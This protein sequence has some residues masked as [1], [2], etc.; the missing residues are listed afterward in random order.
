M[1]DTHTM[2]MVKTAL[3][4]MQR[5]PWEQGVASHAFIDADDTA[6]AIA[7][8]HEAAYRQISDGRLA[9]IGEPG[10]VTD[11]CSPGEA[12]AYAYQKTGDPFFKTAL[13]RVKTWALKN[14][15]RSEEGIVYHVIDRPV[16]WSDSTYML[17]PFLAYIGEYDEAFH[18]MVGYFGLLHAPE[19]N[20]LCHR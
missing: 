1:E 11:P 10:S 14:A 15:P 6:M 9:I 5:Y 18:Q 19:K 2:T 16:V 4:G 17:P 3:L 12:I 7:M 8:A 13:Q 20:M